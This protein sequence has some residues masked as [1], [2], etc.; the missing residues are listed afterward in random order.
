MK[1]KEFVGSFLVKGEQEHEKNVI[2]NLQEVIIVS[3]I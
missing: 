2:I 1:I 3:F